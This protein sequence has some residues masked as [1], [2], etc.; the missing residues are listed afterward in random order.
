MIESDLTKVTSLSLPTRLFVIL[1]MQAKPLVTGR[2]SVQ[3]V[4]QVVEMRQV[5]WC[6]RPVMPWDQLAEFLTFDRFERH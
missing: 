6:S 3:L 5:N 1:F 2:G 4:P